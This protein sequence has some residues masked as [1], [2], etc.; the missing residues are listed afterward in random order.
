MRIL[1]NEFKLLELL[2]N[3]LFANRALVRGENFAIGEGLNSVVKLI[4]IFFH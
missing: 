3:W 1:K 4:L 2:V